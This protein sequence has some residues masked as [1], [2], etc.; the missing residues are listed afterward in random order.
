MA[1]SGD[2]IEDTK[3]SPTTMLWNHMSFV[4]QDVEEEEPSSPLNRRS[5]KRK[6]SGARGSGKGKG[7]GIAT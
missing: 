3:K 5:R 6:V 1:K 4:G 2:S 7:K